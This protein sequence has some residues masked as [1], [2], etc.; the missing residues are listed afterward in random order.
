MTKMYSHFVSVNVC[1]ILSMQDDLIRSSV[2]F[3]RFCLKLICIGG[4]SDILSSIRGKHNIQYH[5]DELKTV[6]MTSY[7]DG[8]CCDA[9]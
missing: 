2:T 9:A 6:T 3:V 8:Y 4:E 1:V 7:Q 5:F